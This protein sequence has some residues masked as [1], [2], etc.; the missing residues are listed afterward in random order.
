M[1]GEVRGFIGKLLTWS[2]LAILADIECENGS[3]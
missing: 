3:C 2:A 1:A